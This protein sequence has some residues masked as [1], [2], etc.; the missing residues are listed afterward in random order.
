MTNFAARLKISMLCA[1]LAAA[2]CATPP[3]NNANSPG[4][5]GTGASLLDVMSEA[6][7][8]QLAAKSYRARMESVSD[9]RKV[10]ATV[11]YLA[12][13]RIHMVSNVNEMIVVGPDTYMKP[14]NGSWQKFPVDVNQIISSFRNPQM[15][16]DL[17]SSADPKLVGADTVDG[18]PTNVYQYTV[19][20]PAGM[21]GTSVAKVWIATTDNLPRKMETESDFS[22]KH[23]KTLV[24]YYDYGADVK[25]EPPM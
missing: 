1:L 4:S 2:A 11:E 9:E 14:A 13:D 12:P 15:I 10:T 6:M 16:E 21:T 7:K 8:A 5:A 23:S 19:K 24:T 20:N 3:T 25:I 22:G 18:I 17:R